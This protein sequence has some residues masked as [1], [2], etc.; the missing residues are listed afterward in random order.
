MRVSAAGHY[1]TRDGR[2]AIITHVTADRAFGRI[3]GYYDR[4]WWYSANGEHAI[5]PIDDLMEVPDP[6]S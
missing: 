6:E 2:T 5:C 4:T 1:L 3:P